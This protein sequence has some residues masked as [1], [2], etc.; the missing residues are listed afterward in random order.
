MN[1]SPNCLNLIRNCESC[2]L[3]AY[4]DTGGVWTIGWGHIGPEVHAGLVWTQAQ[5]DA[6]F[7]SDLANA[8]AS[9]RKLAPNCT[10]GQFD[11]LTDF[12]Y[13]C[14]AGSLST[15]TLLHLHNAGNHTAASAEFGKWC[16]DDGVIEP[17][18]VARRAYE[19]LLYLG[20]PI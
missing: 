15:S 4:Q 20:K 11:A 18:L 6:A 1:P 2:R 7:I 14:G 9:V 3:T 10:Q 13:N 8:A 16:H 5:A 17:G 12:D 19:T